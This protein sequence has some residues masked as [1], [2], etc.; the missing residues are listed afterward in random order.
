M[1][2]KFIDDPKKSICLGSNM[3]VNSGKIIAI[4]NHSTIPENIIKKIT[5]SN[6]HLIFGGII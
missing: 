1:L 3:N 2:S 5:M 4:L 6:F